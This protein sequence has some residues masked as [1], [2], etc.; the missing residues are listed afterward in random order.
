MLSALVGGLLS[1]APA[2]AAGPVVQ[3]SIPASEDGYVSELAPSTVFN[4]DRLSASSK[5]GDRKLTYLSFPTSALPAGAQ[6]V[7]AKL[8]LVRDEHHLPGSVEVSVV[9]N[10][11]WSERSLT[12]ANAPAVGLRLAVVAP[13]RETVE[14]SFLLPVPANAKPAP[15]YSFAVT[16]R[17]RDDVARFRSAEYPTDRPQ[18]LVSYR[19]TVGPPPP[20]PPPP[21]GGGLSD[22]WV[23]AAANEPEPGGGT[24]SSIGVFN[25]SNA[26]IGPLVFR[27]SFDSSLPVSFAG[28]AAGADAAYGYRSFVSW[29]PPNGDFVGAAQ[30]RYDAQVTAW[31]LSVPTTGVYATAYHEPEN[32]M[33]GPQFV[34]MQQHLYSVV[35]A[36]NPSI[37]WGP[38]YMSYWWNPASS[39]YVGDPDAWWPGN[40]YADF[41]AVDTYA[42]QASPLESDPEFR[43]WYDYMLGTGEQM[44]IA[45]YGQYVVPPG[46]VADPAKLAQRAEVIAQDAAWLAAEGTIS[47]WLYW[48]AL[49]EKGD[50]RLNDPDSQDAWQNVAQA[51]RRR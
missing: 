29:K 20:P 46:Q 30:G 44:I 36:A 2:A 37:R 31:A 12:M 22:V 35:K 4:T 21:P 18:L 26:D 14:V 42:L 23:G 49:G 7:E 32:D 17:V 15:T 51:G 41:T 39:H 34:A 13:T 24:D 38:V 48:D 16:S 43:G 47:M 25:E 8:V 28:S 11:R 5:P 3:V 6:I 1:A 40:A 10:T 27:R 9:R 45:E 19:S 33:T 50:W